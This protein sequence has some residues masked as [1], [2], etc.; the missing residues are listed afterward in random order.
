MTVTVYTI[1]TVPMVA[2]SRPRS[3]INRTYTGTSKPTG[4]QRSAVSAT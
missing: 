1:M 2:R 4:S 3:S